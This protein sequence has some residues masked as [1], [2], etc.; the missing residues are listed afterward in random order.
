MQAIQSDIVFISIA[1][2]APDI[3]FA[4]HNHRRTAP[5]G[6]AP[7]F[8]A[9]Y[10]NGPTAAAPWSTR[11]QGVGNLGTAAALARPTGP[12]TWPSHRSGTLI[13]ALPRA[14]LLRAHA[15]STGPQSMGSERLGLPGV[16]CSTT[17]PK[18]SDRARGSGL[19]SGTCAKLFATD[20]DALVDDM[21]PDDATCQ[22]ASTSLRRE[23]APVSSAIVRCGT[24]VWARF[25]SPIANG[26]V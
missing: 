10:A 26:W 15:S 24:A 14:R 4:L 20:P 1:Q 12:P 13:R 19:C 11:V 6:P 23:T 7:V 18:R 8:A 3:V 16:P 2:G 22:Y 9:P 21:P 5:S 25:R 17:S